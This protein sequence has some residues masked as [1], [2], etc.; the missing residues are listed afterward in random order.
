MRKSNK[1]G[2]EEKQKKKTL[3]LPMIYEFESIL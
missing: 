2:C 1:C 3:Q